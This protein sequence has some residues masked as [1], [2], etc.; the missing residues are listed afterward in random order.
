[1]DVGSGDRARTDEGYLDAD[2]I[3]L[4]GSHNRERGH[5]GA[6]LDLEDADGIGFAHG[7]EGE[8]VVDGDFSGIEG[9]VVSAGAAEFDGILD[10][11]HHA[12]PEEIDFDDT[13]VFAIVF[14]PLEDDA[15]GHGGIL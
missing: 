13:E 6:A 2:V 1:M 10:G 11:G 4:P 7:V 12:E 9:A 15:P 5:L 14:V 3:E 8:R